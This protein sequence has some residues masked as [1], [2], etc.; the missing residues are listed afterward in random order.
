MRIILDA[1]GGDK[2]PVEA[3]KGAVDAARDLGTEV[4]LVG[5]ASMLEPHVRGASGVFLV[6]SSETIDPGEQPVTAIRKK[7]TSSMVMGLEMLSRGEGDALVSPGNTG[8]LLAGGLMILGRAAS[9]ER[10]ALA[11]AMPTLV[12]KPL[13][14]LDVGANAEV[15]PRNLLQFGHMGSLYA[16]NVLGLAKPKVAL[17]NIG[18]EPSKG[19]ETCRAAYGLLKESGLEFSGNIEARDMFYGVADVAVCDGFTGNILL[20]FAEG[21]GLAFLGV[22][23]EEITR[24]R[25]LALAAALLKPALARAK[26]RMDYNVYGGAPLLGLAKPCVKCHGSSNAEAFKNG[27]RVALEL[28]RSHAID[29]LSRRLEGLAADM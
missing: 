4:I 3:A 10:P 21:I 18:T 11:V 13:V 7:R 27:V 5:D 28:A 22:M 9:V 12:D 8:A 15:K 17:L 6:P 24:S 26:A 16:E 29:T 25:H 19:T 14:L 23:K 1:M 20:K 2:G